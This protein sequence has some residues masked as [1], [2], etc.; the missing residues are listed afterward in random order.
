MADPIAQ[1]QIHADSDVPATFIQAVKQLAG[2][3]GRYLPRLLWHRGIRE[4]EQLAGYL[5]AANYQPTSA[6][7]FGQEMQ[8]AV[9]RLRQAIERKEAIAIWGDFDADGVTSTA[10]LWDGLGQFFTQNEKLFYY[11]PN[12]F[13]ESHGLSKTGIDQLRHVQV[14]VTCDTGSTNLAEIQYAQSLGIDVIVTDHHTLPESRPPV[15]AI[16]NP[17][18]LEK[19]HPFASLSG[20]AVAYK[21]VEALY[22][23]LPDIPEKPIG[24]LLD[25]VAIG[26]IADLVELK[27][28]CRYLAQ[29][30]IEQLQKQS[31]K[32]ATRPGITRLLELCKRSGD[33][34]TDI[35]FGLG[36]RIN[37]VSRIQGDAHF[38]VELLTSQDVQRCRELADETELANTRRK[39]LQKDVLQQA[40][41]KLA[42]IDLSTTGVIVLWD[43]QWSGGVLGLVAGQIAQ[44]YGKPTIL[45]TIDGEYA[46]GSARSTNQIDLYQLVK[47]QE[48]L[49]HRFGGHPFAAGLSLAIDNLP[50]FAQAINQRL[51]QQSDPPAPTIQADLC[52]TI[53]ELGLEL[54]KELR[55]IEPCGMG[56]PIPKLL[57]QNCWFQAGRNMKLQ[58]L[59]GRK[60]EY[61]RTPFTIW[62]ETVEKGFHG[63]WWGHYAYELPTGRCDAIVELENNTY[64]KRYEVRLVA[65]RACDEVTV[66]AN[67][68]WLLDWRTQRTEEKAIELKTAPASWIEFQTWFRRAINQQLP[69]AISYSQPTLIPAVEIWQTLVGIAKYL[70]RTGK[71]ATR[72]QFYDRLQIGNVAL[73]AGIQALEQ[74]GFHVTYENH[75]FKIT[76]SDA[77][78]DRANIA[79]EQFLTAVREE[80]F[81]RQYFAQVPFS[82]IQAIASQWN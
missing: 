55:L 23:A 30:G 2:I 46:K 20:V 60:V 73:K 7:E 53:D 69:L 58:D 66:S 41:A 4:I 63:V 14:I 9:R 52:V 78:S 36:P 43:E 31:T 35:S 70:S 79:I 76:M 82:T 19:N 59:R 81:Y 5:F 57:I 47:D 12:R 44:E 54:Y 37:A 64:H 10:V 40:K 48:H 80:Q 42:Q 17:R 67:L 38:C 18:S 77:N 51:L 28:D 39:A 22:E 62:D 27:G 75:C 21:L 16:V 72:Q 13:T 65:V 68:Q 6:I 29:K 32:E 24:H 50:L 33:R 11:I 49:L 1:W 61:I 74:F 25:L 45:L 3:E 8:W 56:N 26:L 15:I 71:T 34:P